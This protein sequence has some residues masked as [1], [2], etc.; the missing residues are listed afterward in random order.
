MKPAAARILLPLCLCLLLYAGTLPVFAQIGGGSIVGFV[1]DHTNAVIPDAQVT[2][3]N[4][5]TGVANSATTNNQGYYEFP[6]LPAGN[7]T[8]EATHGGFRPAKSPTF[9]LSTSTKPRVDLK[10]DVGSATS[11]VEVTAQAPLL[12]TTIPDVG[13]VIDSAKVESLPLDGRDWQQLVGL[14]AG[15]NASPS[16]TVG[17]RGGMTF[18][19]SPGYG[20][21]LYLDGVDMSFGEIDSASTDQ[22]AGAGTSL[23]GGVSL[24]AVNEVKVDS[25]SFD[26]EYGDATGGVVNLTSKAGTNLFHGGVWEYFRNDILDANNY[27]SNLNHL[28]KPPLRWNQFGGNIGGP[29]KKDRLF[30]FFNY[31]GARV[32]QAETLSGYVATPL[33]ISQLTPALATN[34][35][36]LP[37]TYAATTNPLLGYSTRNAQTNDSE[38]TTLSRV[39][40]TFGRQRLAAR[41]SYNWSNYLNPAFRPANIQS[42]PYHYYNTVVEH[43]FTLS[44]NKLN[45]F[46][47]GYNRNNLNRHNSTLNVLPGWFEV[48]PV[49]LVGDFQSQIH[50]ITNTYTLSDNFTVIHGPHTFKVGFQGYRLNSTRMQDT[51]LTE[52]YNT[53]AALIADSPASIRITFDTPKDL[54][55]WNFGFYGQDSWR[56]SRRLQLNFGLRYDYFTPLKGGWNLAT[57]NPFGPF[58]TNKGQGMWASNTHNFGPRAGIVW[59]PQGDQKLVVRAGGGLAYMQTQPFFLYDF[60]FI[61]PLIPFSLTVAPS[62]FPPGYNLAFPFPQATFTSQVIA[63]PNSIQNLGIALSRTVADHHLP[64]G[65]SA[66]WNAALQQ[67]LAP[68]LALQISYVGNHVYHLYY[69]TL[70]NQFL[71]H[72]GPRPDPTF[73]TIEI[74]QN[75]ASSS[76]NAL[77]V[78]LNERNYHG[79]VL[80]AYY[81]WGKTLSFGTANDI[82]NIGSNNVQ[83]LSH[84]AGSNGPVDGD[85]RNVFTMYYSYLVPT[86]GFAQHSAIGRAAFGGWHFAGIMSYTSGLPFNVLAGLDLVRNQRITGDRPNAVR[87][88]NPYIRNTRTRVW[89]NS[90]AFDNQTPYNQ[91]VFGNLGYNAVFG[92]RQFN[93]DAGLHKAFKIAEGSTLTFRGEAFNVMNH[94]NFSNPT[95]TMT[96]PTFGQILSGSGG[97]AYQLALTYA[98]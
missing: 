3:T 18:N 9:E 2:A 40:Y 31:E 66:Q 44:S 16:N 41:F 4:L 71:P 83:D 63:N 90:A 81:T 10:L 28:V 24:G 33:L 62:D 51:G 35:E 58:I 27:F 23:M 98:F 39:D 80:D 91:Q 1:S 93:Y 68:N 26:A 12:N 14:Q 79:L 82:N 37:T 53:L 46:R 72:A 5:D 45:E 94:V 21:L 29:I 19:G 97:R 54:G 70:P 43:T 7:Y 89:L 56:L 50:Y 61:N 48:D 36:G 34:I 78:S 32:L 55:S 84:I 17:S 86:A 75:I 25:S 60:G 69:N 30:F 88:A 47:L 64:D 76:Y 20:N 15:G 52:Y 49:S 74:M 87:G 77:Q 59:S 8:V 38:N 95:N 96:T 73:S 13:I 6:L 92:P 22:A 67:T 42:A 65:T 57:S 85:I 11:T